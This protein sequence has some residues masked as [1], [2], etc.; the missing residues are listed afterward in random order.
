MSSPCH[1]DLKN[2]MAIRRIMH[3]HDKFDYKR[4]S[5]SEDI[6]QRKPGHTN[7]TD[8]QADRRTHDSDMSPFPSSRKGV[9]GCK[10]KLMSILHAS[11]QKQRTVGDSLNCL[12]AET[13]DSWWQS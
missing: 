8:R 4:L 13:K 1:L 3:C 10:G 9:K 5:G 11:Q 7:G 12:T 2:S 6:V